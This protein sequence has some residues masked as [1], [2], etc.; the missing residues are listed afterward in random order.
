MNR[1]NLSRALLCCSAV[2]ALALPLPATAM[3]PGDNL[4]W[5]EPPPV[6]P[7]GAK[8]AVLMGDPGKT[9]PYVIRLSFPPGYKVAP[10]QHSAPE[11]VTVI[12]GTLMLGMGD[13]FDSKALK[14]HKTGVFVSIPAKSNHYAMAKT[15]TVVQIHGDGPFDLTYVNPNDD[16]TKVAASK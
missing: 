10:H 6:L 14:T 5:G 13:K 1:F 15:E 8:L 9:G 16:P 3:H 12:S 7:K 4:Q 2:A 11:N